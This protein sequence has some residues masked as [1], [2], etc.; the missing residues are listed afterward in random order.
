MCVDS[1]QPAGLPTIDAFLP[2]VLTFFLQLMLTSAP[3]LITPQ[4]R[5]LS[6]LHSR[7]LPQDMSPFKCSP[8]AQWLGTHASLNI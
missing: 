5:V 6:L 8:G 3:A 4:V 1:S 7:N 2:K